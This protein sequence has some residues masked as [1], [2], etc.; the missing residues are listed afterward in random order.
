MLEEGSFTLIML[1]LSTALG[2]SFLIERFLE[3]VNGLYKKTAFTNLDRFAGVPG[4]QGEILSEPQQ[5]ELEES[6][7]PILFTVDKI[8]PANALETTQVFLLQI[9]GVLAG[10]GICLAVDFGLF[11]PIGLFDGISARLDAL[12]T[13][14]LIGGGSQP[15]HFLIEFLSLRKVAA[16]PAGTLPVVGSQGVIVDSGEDKTCTFDILDVPYNGGYKPESLENRNLRPA[17]PD[18]IVFHHTAMHSDATFED[19]VREIVEVKGWSTGYHSVIASDG[20]IDN[21]CRWDRT[22][23]HALGVNGR[24]LGIALQGNFHTEPGDPFS[25][26]R[27]QF[28]N[29]RP[30]DSQLLSAAKVVALWCHLYKIPVKFG[31]TIVAHR[32]VRAT[33]CAGS[34]FP[35]A[36]FEEL[37]KHCY[38]AWNS[39]EAQTELVFYKQ[40]QYLYSENREV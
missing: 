34:N 20:T 10:T 17:P 2:L 12:L 37:V 18:L 5:E 13:G 16:G 22:G 15:V 33:A 1:L 31:E 30:A 28:G 7:P 29:I 6:H 11:A 23:V 9:L 14:I 40:K 35:S 21:F 25:N 27:G 19:V 3:I 26:D 38:E 39:H 32:E 4:E 36:A 24:S 8:E